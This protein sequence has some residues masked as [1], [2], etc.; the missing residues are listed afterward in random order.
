MASFDGLPDYSSMITSTTF[1]TIEICF[2]LKAA[3]NKYVSRTTLFLSNCFKISCVIRSKPYVWRL[4]FFL[5]FLATSNNVTSC[6]KSSRFVALVIS[7][8]HWLLFGW[9]MLTRNS[10]NVSAFLLSLLH[11]YLIG[12]LSYLVAFHNGYSVSTSA[13]RFPT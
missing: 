9:K 8:S 10:A 12:L 11:W 4:K 3:L 5:I 7:A 2:S 13:T 6:I 1:Q